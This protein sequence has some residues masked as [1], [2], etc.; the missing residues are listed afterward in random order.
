M[1]MVDVD[2]AATSR[3]A[4]KVGWLGLTV[5]A[6]RSLRVHQMNRMNSRTGL[7]MMTAIIITI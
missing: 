3:L 4:T 7:A 5:G 1:A 6:W 2:A